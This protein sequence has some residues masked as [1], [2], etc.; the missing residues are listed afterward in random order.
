MDIW[1]REDGMEQCQYKNA[2]DGLK[3]KFV[4][5]LVSIGCSI[6]MIVPIIGTLIGLYGLIVCSIVGV[7]ALYLISKDIPRI[8]MALIL[9][10]VEIVLATA[11]AASGGMLLLSLARSAVSFLVVFFV[12]KALSESL[13]EHGALEIADKGELVWKLY[14]I[15]T[16]IGM[17]ISIIMYIPILNLIGALVGALTSLASVVASVIYF[18]FLYK[19]YKFYATY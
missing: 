10:V 18:I 16:A 13:A 1:R 11:N 15:C 5:E 9:A 8:K 6:I 14:F 4:A 7:V 19:S 2:A 12:C 17:V 3:Y